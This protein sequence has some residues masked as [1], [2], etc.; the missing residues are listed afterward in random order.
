MSV[1][2]MRVLV[3]LWRCNLDVDDDWR[4]RSLAQLRRMVYRVSIQN[5]QLQRACQLED[6]LD[7][8]LY[9]S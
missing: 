8:T 5:H 3:H 1:G 9:L 6:P 2:Y 4:E 7:L